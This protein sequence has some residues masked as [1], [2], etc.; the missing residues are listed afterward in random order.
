M[1]ILRLSEPWRYLTGAA[2]DSVEDAAVKVGCSV[3]RDSISQ[4][5]PTVEFAGAFLAPARRIYC[6]LAGELDGK[7]E[8]RFVEGSMDHRAAC[9]FFDSGLPD[10]GSSNDAIILLFAMTPALSVPG[11]PKTTSPPAIASSAM[12]SKPLR[13]P[14]I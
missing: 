6:E 14:R 10:N 11:S 7:N 4:T 13:T 12:P 8:P 3:S 9:A 5:L 1:V 2:F